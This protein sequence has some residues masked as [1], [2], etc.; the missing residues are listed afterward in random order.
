M[1]KVAL[2]AQMIEKRIAHAD[3]VLAG[4]PG[5]RQLAE[6][7]NMSRTTVRTAVQQL[8]NCGTLI[9]HENGRLEVA[10]PEGAPKKRIIGFATAAMTSGDIDLWRDGVRAALEGQAV[11][12]RPVAYAHWAD[13]SL[14]EVLSRFDGLFFVAPAEKLPSW[15]TAKMVSTPCRVVVLDQ[16][17]SAAGLPSVTLFPPSA[18]RKLFEHLRLL[19]HR[20]IDC[21]NTQAED[22]VIAGRIAAWRRYL[23]EYG[24]AGEL[25]SRTVQ[26][27]LESAY[28]LIRDALSEGRPVASALFCTTGPAAIGG[29]RALSEAGLRIG[30]DVS[31]CAVNG[32]GIGRYLL[33]SLTELESPPRALYLRRAVEWMLGEGAWKGDLLIQPD[34]VPLFEGESTGPAPASPVV[35]PARH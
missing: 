7:L 18:E 17:E 29:M 16:D 19:G 13:P 1:K 3:H 20:R 26:R 28:Q 6:E 9:R 5:E 31:V 15:L 27:P 30:V 32:E 25:R 34:D 2:A 35:S 14:Q 12:L 24:L 4:I 23:E 22:R 8:V 33:R 11:T 21:L 10:E